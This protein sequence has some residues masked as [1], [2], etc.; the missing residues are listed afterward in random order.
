M[1]DSR[2]DGIRPKGPLSVV[3]K[4]AVQLGNR[5]LEFPENL[6]VQRGQLGFHVLHDGHHLVLLRR[7]PDLP[8]DS[9]HDRSLPDRC[10]F[11]DVDLIRSIGLGDH[12]AGYLFHGKRVPPS[13]TV[14]DQIVIGENVPKRFRYAVPTGIEVS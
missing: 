13:D 2:V 3:P 5:V 6:L 1:S 14:N 8:V 12:R 10:S 11:L 4:P 9:L 7:R